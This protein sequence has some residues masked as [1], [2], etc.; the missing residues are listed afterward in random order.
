MHVLIALPHKSCLET[1][2]PLF[3]ALG[4]EVNTI[5]GDG[6]GL[7]R[8]EMRAFKNAMHACPEAS[9][10]VTASPAPWPIL[11]ALM[12][13]D[14]Q[15]RSLVFYESASTAIG[16]KIEGGSSAFAAATEWLEEAQGLVAFQQAVGRSAALMECGKVISSPRAM[17]RYC[18]DQYLF[19][20]VD[21]TARP[22]ALVGPSQLYTIIADAIIQRDDNVREMMER[23]KANEVKLP[24]AEAVVFDELDDL[25]SSYRK[26][27]ADQRELSRAKLEAESLRKSVALAEEA[28]QALRLK[29]ADTENDGALSNTILDPIASE[30]DELSF[31]RAENARLRHVLSSV[32]GVAEQSVLRAA[33]R[34]ESQNTSNP[35]NETA[36]S[37][38]EENGTGSAV[39]NSGSTKP[40][41]PPRGAL[42]PSLL[43]RAVSRLKFQRWRRIRREAA[44]IA[45]SQLFDADWYLQN[46]EDLQR[47]GVHPAR[48]YAQFGGQEGRAA[49]PGFSSRLYLEAYPDV[50]RE[51]INPLLH[52][53]MVGK[54]E[55]REIRRAD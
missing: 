32:Q 17:L 12:L 7:R 23:L 5:S 42:P 46:N 14:A 4:E 30:Q 20:H 50:A 25:A 10:L 36:E 3:M 53:I 22:N 29:L 21:L 9:V 38:S 39:G 55:G 43:K 18:S 11:S 1:L 27:L 40:E 34:S 51:G 47:Q 33:Q 45:A 52:Y 54:A 15:C 6:Q 2:S 26:L 28:V 49:G 13:E 35:E 8:T 37:A 48:H 41:A 24:S 44:I 31:L 19:D 16:R